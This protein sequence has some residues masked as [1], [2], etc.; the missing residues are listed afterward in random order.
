MNTIFLPQ[1]FKYPTTFF[2]KKLQPQYSLTFKGNP[3]TDT[4]EKTEKPA[5]KRGQFLDNE[6]SVYIRDL[7]CMFRED[8][9]WKKFGDFLEKRFEKCNKVNTYI[10]G[11][12]DGS[13]AYSLSILL[14]SKFGKDAEKFFPIMAKDIDE[15]KISEN[16]KRQKEGCAKAELGYYQMRRRLELKEDEAKQY[17]K[18][19]IGDVCN[20]LI[21][22]KTT[23]PVKFSAANIL[24]D[25]DNIDSK[26]PS[27]IMCR[28]MWPYINENEYNQ[29]AKKLYDRLAPG[30]VVVVGAFDCSGSLLTEQNK[31]ST[32]P[33]I[34]KKYFTCKKIDKEPLIFLKKWR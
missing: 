3:K 2:Q 31:Q 6:G 17:I 27:I 20:D 1:T 5:L 7:T 4:F 10:Y 16:I 25:L 33:D 11:C 9:N 22:D 14:Q 12:S 26:H 13:E 19:T 18:P 23:S 30:S 29:F 24:E 32:F 21:L 34:L 8:L 28:N 15:E